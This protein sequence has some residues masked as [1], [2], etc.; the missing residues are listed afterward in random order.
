MARSAKSVR[1]DPACSNP[2]QKISAKSV[3]IDAAAIRPH[4][5]ARERLL[6]PRCGT[7]RPP[8]SAR[9]FGV[10]TTGDEVLAAVDVLNEAEHHADAGGGES[11]VPVDLLAEPAGRR[12]AR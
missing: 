1:L 11:D 12:A 4:S 6:R 9:V 3:R 2:A 10:P 8:P 5:C 7:V